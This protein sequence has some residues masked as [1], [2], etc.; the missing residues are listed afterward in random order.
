ME[1][2]SWVLDILEEQ[3]DIDWHVQEHAAS[4]LSA[5]IA[6]L[7][8]FVLVASQGLE[9]E[10][11]VDCEECWVFHRKSDTAAPAF[12]DGAQHEYHN[13]HAEMADVDALLTFLLAIDD[14]RH[15][16]EHECA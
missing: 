12:E 10:L 3:I 2:L 5:H 16:F 11:A 6:E 14:D 7:Q 9:R 15:V 4:A 8:L 13:D 1:G